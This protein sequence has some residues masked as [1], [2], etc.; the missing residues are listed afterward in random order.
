MKY[1]VSLIFYRRSMR[2]DWDKGSLQGNQREKNMPGNS[3]HGHN[4]IQTSICLWGGQI[5][6]KLSRKDEIVFKLRDAGNTITTQA[7]ITPPHNQPLPPLHNQP[8]PP[9]HNKPLLPPHN[10]PLPSP[11]NQPLPPPHNQ[12][13]PSP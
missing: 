6:K 1:F 5:Q 9:A 12:P 8:L 11:H 13:L 10:Q 2:K 7:S 4:A 3:K